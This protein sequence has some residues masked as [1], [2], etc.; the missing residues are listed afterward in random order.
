MPYLQLDTPFAHD[1][2]QKR[3]LARRFGEIYAERMGAS[4][5][6]ITVAIRSLGEGALWRCTGDEPYP[7][8]MLMLDIRRGR[9]PESR[10]DL[11]RLMVEA[12]KEILGYTDAQVN[13]EFTQHDGD[14]MYHTLYGGLSEDWRPGEPDRL[15]E[16]RSPEEAG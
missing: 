7:A 1:A 9:P 11:A 13:V 8:A 16:G 3:R 4:P 5:H 14:E 6:R 10:A 15:T 12:C 2:G